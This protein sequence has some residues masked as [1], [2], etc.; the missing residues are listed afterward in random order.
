MSRKHLEK[1]FESF[2]LAPYKQYFERNIIFICLYKSA[3]HCEFDGCRTDQV[4]ATLLQAMIFPR[5]ILHHFLVLF[6]SKHE[7]AMNHLQT[8]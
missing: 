5:S 8:D 1:L 6:V 3:I 7:D 2:Q 4:N